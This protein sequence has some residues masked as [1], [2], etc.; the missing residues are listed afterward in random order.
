[1]DRLFRH[2]LAVPWCWGLPRSTRRR[3]V[4]VANEF[5]SANGIRTYDPMVNSNGANLKADLE[6]TAKIESSLPRSCLPIE[7]A[8]PFAKSTEWWTRET[9]YLSLYWHKAY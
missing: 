6:G 7:L 8:I 9:K 5:G 3:R 2:I 1:M 4:L